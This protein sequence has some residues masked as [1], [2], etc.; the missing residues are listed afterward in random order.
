MK[1]L[2]R[3]DQLTASKHQANQ[4]SNVQATRQP[5]DSKTPTQTTNYTPNQSQSESQSQTQ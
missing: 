4:A 3:F 1:K 2:I 5:V